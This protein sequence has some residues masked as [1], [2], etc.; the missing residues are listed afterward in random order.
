MTAVFT[1]CR[2]WQ[3]GETMYSTKQAFTLIEL[4]VV[5]LIIGILAAVALPQ[6][7]K[8]VLKSRFAEAR[9]NLKTVGQALKLCVL[10]AD[11]NDCS[12]YQYGL[13]VEIGSEHTGG[14]QTENFVYDGLWF[15]GS[16]SPAVAWAGYK[17]GINGDKGCVCYYPMT[18]T[19]K[20]GE[21][22][23]AEEEGTS[24]VDYENIVG[25]TYDANCGCC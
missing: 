14:R 9:V 23:C 25:L 4:L 20:L 8:A 21:N 19:W 1:A 2:A 24:T 6:Y 11:D 3:T 17:K 12:L 22:L 18:E 7:Q 13:D 16:P 5:V 10:Q 15:S